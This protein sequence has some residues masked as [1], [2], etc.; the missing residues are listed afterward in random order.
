MFGTCWDDEK[1]G[2][3]IKGY[4]C[5]FVVVKFIAKIN[6]ETTSPKAHPVHRDY[7]FSTECTSK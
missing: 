4:P 5:G 7:Q 3:C 2:T 6:V 1:V